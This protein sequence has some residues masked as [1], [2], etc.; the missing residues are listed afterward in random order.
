MAWI[1]CISQAVSENKEVQAYKKGKNLI[2]FEDVDVGYTMDMISRGGNLVAGSVIRRASEKSVR[3]IHDEIR[4]AQVEKPTHGTIVG[5]S[6]GARLAGTFQSLPGI[7]RRIG[8]RWYAGNPELRKKTQGTVGIT[9]VGNI[10]GSSTGMWGCPLVTGMYPLMFGISGISRKPGIVGEKIEPREYLAMSVML[11]HDA[12]DGAEAARFL[13][14]LGE[15]FIE[16][17][18]LENLAPA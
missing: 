10:L 16:G 3:Q 12:V 6:E 11:D 18:G 15:L 4:A 7:L 5:E 8:T 2:V 14:R 13:K 17:F 1:K 9:S